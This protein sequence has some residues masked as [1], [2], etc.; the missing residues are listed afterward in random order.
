[1]KRRRKR[2]SPGMQQMVMHTRDKTTS[3]QARIEDQSE[4]WYLNP[5]YNFKDA[6]ADI[7]KRLISQTSF[8]IKLMDPGRIRV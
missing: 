8:W 2:K 4:S 5:R 6:L 3:Q 7:N 1:M